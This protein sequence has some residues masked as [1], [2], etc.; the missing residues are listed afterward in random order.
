MQ[1]TEIRHWPAA[2]GLVAIDAV[3]KN[4]ALVLKVGGSD[5]TYEVLLTSAEARDV[6]LALDSLAKAQ[7]A[8]PWAR[9]GGHDGEEE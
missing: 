1:K 9:K 2:G 5:H 7:Q 3:E 4:G 8:P 6:A